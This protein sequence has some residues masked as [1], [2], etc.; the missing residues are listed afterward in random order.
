MTAGS[1]AEG[2]KIAR[3]L[4]R[5]RVAA[6]INVVPGVTSLYWWKG[7]QERAREVLLVI[8]TSAARIPQLIRE[9][10]RLHSYT[11]PEVLALP[12]LAGNP[13]YLKWVREETRG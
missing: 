13:E 2:E 7:K 6:C 10:K 12:V 5:S 1:R 9:V 4:L 8:K 11:V 3:G